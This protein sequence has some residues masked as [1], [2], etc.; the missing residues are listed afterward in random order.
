MHP[1]LYP[2][3]LRI[4]AGDLVETVRIERA[5]N[6]DELMVAALRD[7]SKQVT[8]GFRGVGVGLVQPELF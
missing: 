8:F 7:M 5:V 3:E 1:R 2:L 4:L 6:S